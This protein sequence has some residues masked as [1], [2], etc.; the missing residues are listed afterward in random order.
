MPLSSLRSLLNPAFSERYGIP[1][2]NVFDDV[3]L[4]GVLSGAE[5]A[6]APV[7]V[8]VSV[9]TLTFWGLEA[10]GD[11]A[12]ARARAAA[13][14]VCLH[15]DHCPDPELAVACLRAGWS[16]VLFDGSSR[17]YEENRRI[18]REVR[19]VADDVGGAVEGELT[20]IAR[21]EDPGS[22]SVQG[23]PRSVD[24]VVD[25]IES[26]G[27]DCYAPAIGTAHGQYA[28]APD[29]RYE[30]IPAILERVA[31][32][33]VL[34]GGT[35][36]EDG[37]FRRLIDQGTA[38][39]NISTALKDAYAR[40]FTAALPA[41]DAGC[42]PLRLLEGVTTRIRDFSLRYFEVFGSAGWAR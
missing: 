18:T 9:K 41:E 19:R 38:K 20:P 5:L 29:I 14:P 25:F 27:I 16:S 23:A 7:I 4:Q 33:M 34:H 12:K 17:S 6:E 31:I 1:A 42:N 39:V 24:E 8:Q 28:E 35:G 2:F 3:S 37:V 10:F 30:R 11:M 13:V 32:P 36:L 21:V 22:G 15:L 40:A 26:T